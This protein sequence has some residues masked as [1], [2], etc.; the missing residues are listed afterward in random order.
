MFDI[1]PSEFAQLPRETRDFYQR[2]GRFD[3]SL[4]LAESMMQLPVGAQEY[5]KRIARSSALYGQ[6]VADMHV[7]FRAVQDLSVSKARFDS[8]RLGLGSIGLEVED[9]SGSTLKAGGL[10]NEGDVRADLFLD[11]NSAAA[12]DVKES[13]PALFG[14]KEGVSGNVMYM[15]VHGALCVQKYGQEV[16]PYANAWRIGVNGFE[17]RPGEGLEEKL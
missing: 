3:I 6:D 7:F 13:Y 4:D 8:V 9:Y 12:K 14:E 5:L 17:R 1:K 11:L 16:L 10:V 2:M 15:N